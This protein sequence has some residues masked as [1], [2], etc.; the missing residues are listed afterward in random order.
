ME[1][2][3]FWKLILC[4]DIVIEK[5]RKERLLEELMNKKY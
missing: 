4:G 1:N 3:N 2:V 5:V